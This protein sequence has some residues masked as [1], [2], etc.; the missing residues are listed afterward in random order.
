MDTIN[1][2]RVNEHQSKSTQI[3]VK[4]D[5]FFILW[6]F[7]CFDCKKTIFS[8]YIFIYSIN[9]IHIIYINI[10]VKLPH[11]NFLPTYFQKIKLLKM[12]SDQYSVY[13][14]GAC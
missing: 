1:Y 12:K 14:T 13:C 10:Y 9:D 3:L 7:N 2:L 5:N 4:R 11:Y 8:L 6:L